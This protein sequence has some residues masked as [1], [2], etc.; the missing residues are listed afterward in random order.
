M[1]TE[2]LSS[3]ENRMKKAV[4]ALNRE[5]DGVRTGRARPAL[6]E[7][8]PMDY[9]GVPTPLNQLAT[10]SA[11]EARLIVIQPWDR[12]VLPNIEKAILKSEL[13]LNPTNDGSAI[14]LSFPPLSEERR[15]ELVRLVHRKVEE[16]RVSVRN[17]RRDEVEKVRGME[18]NKELS[19]DESHRTQDQI[20][21]LTDTYIAQMDR[22]GQAKEAE[23]MEV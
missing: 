5:L 19:Q 15:R 13:G 2:V 10:I 4:E 20:Q 9:F 11:P 8:L 6:V 16:G 14:R 7:H 1:V 17:I 22:L 21:K 23:V 12:Q 18:K 3:G